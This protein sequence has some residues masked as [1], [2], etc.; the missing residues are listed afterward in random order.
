MKTI[1]LLVPKMGEGI[2]EVNVIKW[3]KK[4][5]ESFKSEEPIVEI[6]TDKVDSELPTPYSGVIH[7]FLVK[8]GEN[9]SVGTPL[10]ILKIEN[11]IDHDHQSTFEKTDNLN[12]GNQLSNSQKI[13]NKVNKED[14]NKQRVLS[15]KYSPLVLNIAKTNGIE[16][17]E[18]DKIYGSAK[19]GRV[20]KEDIFEYLKIKSNDKSKNKSNSIK[21]QIII[22]EGDKKIKLDRI[23][24]VTA[25]KMVQSNQEIP[26]VISF[27][28][29]DITELVKWRST[30]KSKFEKKFGISLTFTSFFIWAIAKAL[31]EFPI[32]NSHFYDED[33]LI[34][35][36]NINIG[37]A[38]ALENNNL[39]I[40]VI[41]NADNYSFPDLVIK[42]SEIVNKARSKQ[43]KPEDITEA[44]YSVS[45]IGVFDT[46]MG[47]PMITPPQVG[48]MAIG[49]I[50]TVPEIKKNKNGNTII[51][52]QKLILS[53]S[54]DHRVI[55]G[56]IGGLFAKK[57]ADL[58]KS[59][60]LDL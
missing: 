30:N 19:G 29:A 6:A 46:L 39:V 13:P 11:S 57:V 33:N 14:L 44:T 22:S 7:K 24:K 38:V 27:V 9:A 56:A 23:R 32:V 41:K 58:L 43:L 59:F 26:H 49:T 34:L 20:I 15:R 48:V 60:N 2:I 10:A 47:T 17:S 52:K 45:N 21:K 18:L 3:L 31:K 36:K 42:I 50:K 37:I 12:T 28:E 35:K 16:I 54:Y 51:E 4:E 25:Q 40:P 53:H 55:D 1:E 8:E 5:G